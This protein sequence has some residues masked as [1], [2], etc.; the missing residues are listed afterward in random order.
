MGVA[1]LLGVMRLGFDC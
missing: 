1:L